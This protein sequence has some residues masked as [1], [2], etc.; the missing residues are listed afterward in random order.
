MAEDLGSTNIT[1]LIN[2]DDTDMNDEMVNKILNELENSEP[3]NDNNNFNIENDN[4]DNTFEQEISN[5]FSKNRNP[6]LDFRD[7]DFRDPDFNQTNINLESEN[8]VNKINS[9]INDSNGLELSSISSIINKLKIPI[10]VFILSIV[11]NN[12]MVI[13]ILYNL[14]F[15]IIKNKNISSYISLFLRTIFIS[16]ILFLLNYFDL[17]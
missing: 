5:T 14:L 11:F 2:E 13:E 1:D 4:M 16:I 9:I 17:I 3:S 15:N 6:T 7:P 10:I 8:T 12:P